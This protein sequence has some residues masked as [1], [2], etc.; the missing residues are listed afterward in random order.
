[1][2]GGLGHRLQ[3]LDRLDRG[4][5]GGAL[6]HE[7]HRREAGE[8]IFGRVEL[9]QVLLG[10]RGR[11]AIAGGGGGLQVAPAD[12][13]TSTPAVEVEGALRGGRVDPVQGW[14][15][16]VVGQR[17]AAQA[18]GGEVL[19]TLLGERLV[20]A[21]AA[22]VGGHGHRRG[23]GGAD[24]HL[25]HHRGRRD[26]VGQARALEELERKGD[27][28]AL[29]GA[30]LHG[31]GVAEADLHHVAAA[32]ELVLIYALGHADA[33]GRV[34]PGGEGLVVGVALAEAAGGYLQRVHHEQGPTGLDAQLTLEVGH[35]R[36]ALAD[37]LLLFGREGGLR[38]C[39]AGTH[40]GTHQRGGSEGSS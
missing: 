25:V 3:R 2:Y 32:R 21:V 36:Q 5:A 38:L 6:G 14:Q 20:H 31:D 19:D 22:E 33:G 8:L 12:G 37:D 35:R 34:E 29:G 9:G 17:Q 30:R 11:A 1:M 28:A 7:R 26:L 4:R 24:V 39:G 40:Q 15:R 10:H 16:R 23:L 18:G 13:H 27:L